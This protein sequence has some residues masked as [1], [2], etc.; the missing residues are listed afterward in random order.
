MAL[1]C[2]AALCAVAPSANAACANEA[3]RAS[4]SSEA[5]PSGTVSFPECMALEMV[6]PP[7]KFGQ[8]A[9]ELSAFSLDGS[10]A[11]FISK[12]AL[13]GTEGLHVFGG[14]SYVATRGAAGWTTAPTSPPAAAAIVQGGQRVGGPF[15]FAPDLGAWVLFGATQAQDL[16]GE[17]QFFAGALN[18]AFSPLSPL[19]VPIDDSGQS[20]QTTNANVGLRGTAADLT[21]SVLSHF[22]SSTAYLP[23]DPRGGVGDGTNSYV[24]FLDAQGQPSLELLARDKA[25]TVYGGRCGSQ[26][27]NGGRNQ[28]AIS[29]DGSRIYFSTRPAQ[30]ASIGAQG[31]PCDTA[32]PL[33]IFERTQTPA[34][35]EIKELIPGEPSAPGDDRYQGASVDGSKLYLTSP[36]NL[37]ASDQDPSAEACSTTVGASAGCDLYLYDSSKAPAERLSLVSAGAGGDPEPGKD[38]DVLGT[39]AISSDGSHVY[40]AAQ[41]V[42][43]SDQNP[44]GDSAQEGEPNLYLHRSDSGEL[45]FL[46]TLAAA[47]AEQLWEAPSFVGAASAVP[48]LGDGPQAGGDGHILL[49]ASKAPLTGTSDDNDG[50]FRDVFRYDAEAQALER[51]S[52]AAAGG[53]EVPGADVGVN[54]NENPPSSNFAEQGRWV[55]EDG[56]AVAFASAEPLVPGDEDGAINP[57]LWKEGQMVRLPGEIKLARLRPYRPSLSASGEEAGFTTTEALLPADGDATADVYVARVD[58]GFPNPME[59]AT[60]DPLSEGACQGPPTGPLSGPAPATPFFTGP[61]NEKAPPKCRKG[62]VRKRGKCVNKPGK[63]K[64]QS[65][66]RK[67]ASHKHGGSK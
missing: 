45:S 20:L 41:G 36:R 14:D 61:G 24:A 53:S 17:A 1:F 31:P 67:R 59:P 58:G 43:T 3:I 64:K 50:G 34:G 19:L 42:L 44:V 49:L 60:C 63:S 66:Q 52:K 6:S 12:A 18:G 5:L 16:A 29:T 33:R 27:G 37:T 11:L 7:K 47:D 28:G 55:S 30:P 22:Y 46:G 35:P 65:K 32:N 54:S 23:G 48:L 10:R 57:Y 38:A 51:V 25:G 26:L 40:F 9:S 62:K 15:A 13:A 56:R 21:A 8:E 39:V 4:Q 2:L